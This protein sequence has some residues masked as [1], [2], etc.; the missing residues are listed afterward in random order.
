MKKTSRSSHGEVASFEQEKVSK[1]KIFKTKAV[2]RKTVR[3]SQKI[4]ERKRCAEVRLKVPR[5]CSGKDG[6][7]TGGGKHSDVSEK[8][9]RWSLAS[10]RAYIGG[11]NP[12]DQINTFP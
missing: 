8:V 3:E 11:G 9:G 5:H 4:K 10:E 7:V 6:G 2:Q 1:K 12:F